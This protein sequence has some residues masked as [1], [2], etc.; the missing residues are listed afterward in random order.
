MLGVLLNTVEIPVE[1]Y[2]INKKK[3]TCL[4]NKELTDVYF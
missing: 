1:G 3:M 4:I 2:L